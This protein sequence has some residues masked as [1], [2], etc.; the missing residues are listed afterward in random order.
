[1]LYGVFIPRISFYDKQDD[2]Y[3]KYIKQL[4]CIC[5]V[6]LFNLGTPVFTAL[7]P[8]VELPSICF[9]AA[10]WTIV[11]HHPE[12]TAFSNVIFFLRTAWSSSNRRGNSRNRV[13]GQASCLPL[14]EQSTKFHCWK[15]VQ[16]SCC[17]TGTLLCHMHTPQALLPGMEASYNWK[18]IYSCLPCGK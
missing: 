18:G 3:K 4:F 10:A 5:T 13:L 15:R 12:N 8:C 16:C 14:A 2:T 11:C 17:Q 1:M 7:F 9:F 6:S